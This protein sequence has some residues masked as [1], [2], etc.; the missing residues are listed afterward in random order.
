MELLSTQKPETV[1]K[2][3]MTYMI[4][5]NMIRALMW[6]AGQLS[7]VDPLRLSFAGSVQHLE[8]MSPHLGQAPTVAEHRRLVQALY[9][10]IAGEALPNRPNRAEPRV[11]KRRPKSFPLMTKPRKELKKLLQG[12]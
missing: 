9:D 11:R 8:H 10:L 6:R 1:R 3:I 2:E 7:G 4:A 5:Y 12:R